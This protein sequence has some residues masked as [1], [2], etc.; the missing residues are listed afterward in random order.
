M[1]TMRMVRIA[2]LWPSRWQPREAFDAEALMELAL[3]IQELGL[4]NPVVVFKR[5]DGE[6]ELVA[7][8]RREI[9]RAHV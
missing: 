9:G 8:E 3:S 7:G 5:D 2:E 1:G 6:W 4:I